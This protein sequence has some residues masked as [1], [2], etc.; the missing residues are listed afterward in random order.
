[1]DKSITVIDV[2]ETVIGEKLTLSFLS[3][4]STL[5]VIIRQR[6]ADAHRAYEESCPFPKPIIM[7]NEVSPYIHPQWSIGKELGSHLSDMSIPGNIVHI[8]NHIKK[9]LLYYHRIVLPC[10]FSYICDYYTR[11]GEPTYERD[12]I[13]FINYLRLYAKL[14]EL[15]QKGI[16]IF[17]PEIPSFFPARDAVADLPQL[18]NWSVFNDDGPVLILR[19]IIEQSLWVGKEFGLD[20]FLPS[21]GAITFFNKYSE[22]CRKALPESRVVDASVGELLLNC[23]LPAVDFLSLED[24]ICVREGSDSFLAWRSSLRSVLERMY[25]DQLH[26]TFNE[27]ELRRLA[28]EE[29]AAA[30]IAVNKEISKSSFL[31]LT[32]DSGVRTVGIGVLTRLLTEMA[33]PGAGLI[34]A[35]ATAGF[36]FLWDYTRWKF[37]ATERKQLGAIKSHYAVWE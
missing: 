30:R 10:G 19:N 35:T 17:L 1:M 28:F 7:N 8:E 15:I 32:K 24:M 26:G 25:S 6:L 5:D 37:K 3:D 31:S 4:D 9:L 18:D 33:A 14:R 34:T 27:A 16:V 13:A 20:L 36:T 29:F 21:K 22:V 2:I 23:K 12:K 11:G